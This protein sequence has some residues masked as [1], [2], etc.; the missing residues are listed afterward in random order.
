MIE[1]MCTCC[2]VSRP[3]GYLCNWPNVWVC[4]HCKEMALRGMWTMGVT[5]TSANPLIDDL[6]KNSAYND[7]LSYQFNYRNK[8]GE[9]RVFY[10]PHPG[11]ELGPKRDSENNSHDPLDNL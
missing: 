9:W 2:G 4:G 10:I 5:M 1:Q 11:F 3:R 8:D 7:G 6:C